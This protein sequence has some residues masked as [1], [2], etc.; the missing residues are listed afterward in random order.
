MS[1]LQPRV[2]LA[3]PDLSEAS[4]DRDP[5]REFRAWFDAIKASGVPMPEAMTL[6]TATAGGV[7]S[8]RIVLLRGL[9][10]RGFVF[11]T[12]FESRK[13][14]ELDANPWAA[15]AFFWP[16]TE[17]QVRVEG[18]VERVSAAQSDAYFA[19]RPWGSRLSAIA[20]PQS[21][22]ILDRQALARRV[23]DLEQEYS[24]R[25]IPRPVHWGGYRVVPMAVE[26]WQ[27]Q[28]NRLHHR[29]R[30]RRQ[31]DGWVVERLAP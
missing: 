4:A 1:E 5:L 29:L 11:F 7:P 31:D 9:D 2:P 17:R 20:S 3:L 18:T 21:Q 24:D 30:Y 28:P 19:S 10:E 14:H 25:P 13:G 22:V 23:R 8:A 16:G 6:A 26:F 15:L 27:G 12:N